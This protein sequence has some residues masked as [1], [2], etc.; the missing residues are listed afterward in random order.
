[1]TVLWLVIGSLPGVTVGWLLLRVIERGTPVLWTSERWAAGTLIGTI[2]CGYWHFLAHWIFQVPL[3]R[4]GFLA[5]FVTLLGLLVP[6]WLFTRPRS[7]ARPPLAPSAPSQPLSR[8]H[9]AVLGLLIGWIVIR[10]VTLGAVFSQVPTYF[11]DSLDN[12]NFRAKAIFHSH[13]LDLVLPDGSAPGVTAY[14]PAIPLYKAWLASA[15]GAWS[16]PLINAPHAVWYVLILWLL[17]LNLRRRLPLHWAIGGTYI[18]GS[19]PLYQI[20]GTNSYLDALVSGLVLLLTGYLVHALAAESDTERRCFLRLSTCAV[21][22]LCFTKS[23][24]IA[25]YLPLYLVTVTST[26]ALG[27]RSGHIT[28][29]DA[30]HWA[31]HMAGWTLIVILPFVLYRSIHGLTFGN[32]KALSELAIAWHPKALHTIALTTFQEGNWHFLYGALAV[33]LAWRWRQALRW[34]WWPLTALTVGGMLLQIFVFS[35]TS[36]AVEA[37]QQ[38]GSARG[39]VQLTPLAVFLAIVLLHGVLTDARR[40]PS[41]T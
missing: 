18:L 36:L 26:L 34:P 16:D 19:L 29:A 24:G 31:W 2:V 40:S 38:T 8:L 20:H 14:P 5:G 27:L 28:W 25:L 33:L 41:A 7:P 13:S 11:D 4:L 1:M 35:F 30:R 22:A 9:T 12:W 3:T 21:A 37:I 23:E 32:A 10:V 17:Y 39:F 15:A 6:L